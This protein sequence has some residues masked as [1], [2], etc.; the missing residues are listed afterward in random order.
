[1]P[2]NNGDDL[3]QEIK[4]NRSENTGVEIPRIPNIDLNQPA[5]SAETQAIIKGFCFVNFHLINNCQK[6]TCI[7]RL[8]LEIWILHYQMVVSDEQIA[9]KE[10]DNLDK[11]YIDLESSIK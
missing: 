5:F 6:W 9:K 4:P 8:D 2:D 3:A 7:C 10:Y 1:M 11:R